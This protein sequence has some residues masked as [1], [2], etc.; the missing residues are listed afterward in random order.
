M[1]EQLIAAAY[2]WLEPSL[3]VWPRDHKLGT[4]CI[5][6]VCE[7][8]ACVKREAIAAFVAWYEQRSR[9]LVK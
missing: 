5:H 3:G 8:P 7:H 4:A 1:I 2:V 6:R 9:A